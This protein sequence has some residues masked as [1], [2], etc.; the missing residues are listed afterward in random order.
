MQQ[1]PTSVP[2]DDIDTED[3]YFS[4]KEIIDRHER[5]TRPLDSRPARSLPA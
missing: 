1:S 2:A 4:R 3:E 5:E